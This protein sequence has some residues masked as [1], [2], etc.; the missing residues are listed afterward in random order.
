LLAKLD[1]AQE[2]ILILDTETETV[3]K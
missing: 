2:G 1:D 3:I